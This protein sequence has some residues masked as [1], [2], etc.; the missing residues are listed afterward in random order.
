[1]NLAVDLGNT[2]GK[3]SVFDGAK[4]VASFSF[5][6]LRVHDLEKIFRKYPVQSSI[7]ASVIKDDAAIKSFLK[8]RTHFL[9][10]NASLPLPIK[11]KYKTPRTLGSDR[12]ACAI[13]GAKLFPKQNVLII[14]GGTCIK[15]DFV[16]AKGEYLGGSISPGLAMR[17]KALNYFTQ[18]LPLVNVPRQTLNSKL[19]TTNFI[20]ASTEESIR[21]GVE[22]GIIGE[23]NGFAEIYSRRLRSL[24][25]VFTGGD[26]ARFAAV[27]NFRTFAAPDLV[28]TGLNEILRYNDTNE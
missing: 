9:K 11:I 13:G 12:I 15:Y 22:Q 3:L 19:Q 4:L 24:K 5:S 2:Q 16:N 28:A 7:L 20:G 27:V 14:D 17:F 6:K 1:M 25:I 18:R 26:A 21:T 10:L 23:L 8:K